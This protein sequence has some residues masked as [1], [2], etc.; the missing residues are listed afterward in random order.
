MDKMK[1]KSLLFR[2]IS[3]NS[4]T[5]LIDKKIMPLIIY[6]KAIDAPLQMPDGYM[7]LGM[8]FEGEFLSI[9]QNDVVYVYMADENRT[10]STI[11]YEDKIQK[12]NYQITNNGNT[13]FVLDKGLIINIRDEQ[14]SELS[15]LEIINRKKSL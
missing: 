5:S 2:T 4:A 12:A 3:S 7:R 8:V 1:Y 15:R 14:I 13:T 10:F 9:P 11:T 6:N